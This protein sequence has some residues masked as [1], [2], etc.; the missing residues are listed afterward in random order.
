M[1]LIPMNYNT[2]KSTQYFESNIF[3]NTFSN[4]ITY[5]INNIIKYGVENPTFTQ[6]NSY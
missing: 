1:V 5:Y 6:L 3:M 4:Q 2:A